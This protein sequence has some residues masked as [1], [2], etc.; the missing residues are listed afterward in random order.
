MLYYSFATRY[1]N[2]KEPLMAHGMDRMKI[3][4]TLAFTLAFVMVVIAYSADLDF[5]GKWRG[6]IGSAG[7]AAP[8]AA[9]APVGRGGGGGGRGGGGFGG[10][11]FGGGGGGG[12]QKVT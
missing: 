11:G 10:G 7:G 1:T 4:I 8:N 2:G 6:E 3:G 12:P 5:G 9:G